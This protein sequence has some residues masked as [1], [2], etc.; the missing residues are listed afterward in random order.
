MLL[1]NTPVQSTRRRSGLKLAVS[2][3]EVLSFQAGLE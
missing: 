1:Q 3:R 2:P